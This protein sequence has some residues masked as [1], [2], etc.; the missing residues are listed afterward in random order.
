MTDDPDNVNEGREPEDIIAEDSVVDDQES[1]GENPPEEDSDISQDNENKIQKNE[2][3]FD[4]EKKHGDISK[5]YY[6]MAEKEDYY[7]SY[8]YLN[9]VTRTDKFG[10]LIIKLAGNPGKIIDMG[11]GT[12]LWTRILSEMGQVTGID[13]SEARIEIAKERNPSSEY[14]VGDL[15]EMPSMIKD[16]SVGMFFSCCS[17]YCLTRESQTKIFTDCFRLLYPGGKLIMI[18]PNNDNLFREKSEIKYP[19]GKNDT[20]QLLELMGYNNIIIK[21]YNFI[22]RNFIRD[23]GILYNLLIPFEK[24]LEFLHIP[25][26]GSLLIY[27][28]KPM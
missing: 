14:V 18:E 10:P 26:S 17:L 20:N 7:N 16:G 3:D 6:S 9:K 22:P 23:R 12:G 15:K 5:K 13:F 8:E 19:F 27:A 1:F 21:N 2:I 25:W 24:F 28:E 4:N 11:C